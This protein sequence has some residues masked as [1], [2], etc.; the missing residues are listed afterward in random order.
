MVCSVIPAWSLSD[1]EQSHAFQPP[2][3]KISYAEARQTIETSLLRW[4]SP[5]EHC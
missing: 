3:A 4:N 2:D 5:V 1:P